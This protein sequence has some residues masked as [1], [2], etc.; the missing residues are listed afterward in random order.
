MDAYSSDWPL[1][2]S[3]TYLMLQNHLQQLEMKSISN[4]MRNGF[5]ANSRRQINCGNIHNYLFLCSHLW[6]SGGFDT[7]T[8]CVSYINP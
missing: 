3:P 5:E 7:I 6:I 8:L 4:P 2:I 1:N